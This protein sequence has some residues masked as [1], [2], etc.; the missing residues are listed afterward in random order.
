MTDPALMVLDEPMTSLD[1][2]G[3]RLF[4]QLIRD[5]HAGG[6]TVLWINHDLDQ[7]ARMAQD[8]T[9]IERRVLASG[10]VASTLS[11]DMKRGVYARVA[12]EA[13]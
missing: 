2:N 6:T 13:A 10:P 1:E 8:L 4:E 5:I 12:G 9:V 7:V 3:S 11:D